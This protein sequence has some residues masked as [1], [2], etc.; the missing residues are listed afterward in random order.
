VLDRF[1][2]ST[3][4]LFSQSKDNNRS[5]DHRFPLSEGEE[6]RRPT[7]SRILHRGCVRCSWMQ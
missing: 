5:G 2:V 6:I 3:K 7:P 4:S 1:S